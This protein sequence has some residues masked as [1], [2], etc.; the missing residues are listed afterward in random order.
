MMTAPYDHPLDLTTQS[1][2]TYGSWGLT[3]VLLAY[4]VRLGLRQRTP[5]FVLIVLAAMIGAFFEPLYDVGFM[6]LFY[7]PG[8]W[9]HFTAFD[10]PQPLWTHSGYAILYALPAIAITNGIGNGTMTRSGLYKWAAVE[11]AMSCCFEMIGIN[12]G[13]YTYWGPHV[14]RIANYPL[15]IGVLETAQVVC[16]SIAA[17]ELRRRTQG[18]TPLLGLFVLFP[19]MFFFANFGAGAPTI[20]AL[21]TQDAGV[22][23]IAAGTLLSIACAGVLIFAASRL[24]P[25]TAS[26]TGKP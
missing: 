25:V 26:A 19:C 8:I 14:L 11:L 17:S 15:V 20:V 3:V 12:G 22:V 16:F 1:I 6:L 2:L 23:L 7:V 4:A 21:H 24:L 10:I 5:F 13:A 9:S 18:A